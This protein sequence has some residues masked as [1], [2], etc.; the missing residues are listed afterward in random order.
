MPFVRGRMGMAGLLALTLALG[1]CGRE[2]EGAQP[3]GGGPGGGG[4]HGPGGRGGGGGPPAVET[5]AVETGS[6]AREIE[7]TGTVEPLRSV[8]VNAQAAGALVAVNAEEGD[9][10]QRGAVMAR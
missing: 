6:I 7:V 3:K 5:A 10:V 1:A 9:Y 2:S 8:G 4:G